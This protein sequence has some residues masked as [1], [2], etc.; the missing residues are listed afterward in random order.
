MKYK[1]NSFFLIVFF[2]LFVFQDAVSM[3]F[4]VF[5]YYDEVFCLLIIPI[6]LYF[7]SKENNVLKVKKKDI[8]VLI[9]LC[10]YLLIGVISYF[11][12]SNQ[13]IQALIGDMFLNLKFFLSIYIGHYLI[14]DKNITPQYFICFIKIITLLLFVLLIIN[15]VYPIFDNQEMRFG[16]PIPK[17]FY[18][19]SGYLAAA[20]TLL[21]AMTYRFYNK[22]YKANLYML[23][24]VLIIF[25][26]LRYKAMATAII[27]TFVFFIVI[28]NKKKIKWWHIITGIIIILIFSWD[29]VVFYYGS[30]SIENA[31][32]ALTITAFEI[33]KNAFPFGVGF[34]SYG[35]YMSRVYY[36][37]VYTTYGLNNIWGLSK[38]YPFFISDTFWP[39][40]IGQTG[41]L[42]TL[43][44]LKIIF[45]II[46]KIMKF[47]N[48]YSYISGITVFVYLLLESTSSSAFVS[49]NAV[50]FGLWLGVLL[51]EDLKQKGVK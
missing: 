36:S 25:F 44:Y 26:T 1:I 32:G 15:F 21:L 34:G 29:Q 37:S 18:S 49:L 27:C 22:M 24:Q 45:S 10:L 4:P 20:G 17:L 23:L 2:S 46:K 19:H 14:K 7:I 42:G 48:R 9:D 30:Q 12:N 39:M 11:L 8:Q 41:L 50:S 38:T 16:I 47:E 51:A 40:I 5:K 6:S 3:L 35:S 31:R 13:P 33:S 28:V 43:F